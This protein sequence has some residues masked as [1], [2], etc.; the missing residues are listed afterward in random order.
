MTDVTPVVLLKTHSPKTR[1][2]RTIPITDE[3]ENE[4]V[5]IP[6]LVG[7]DNDLAEM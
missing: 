7:N 1:L 2:D 3:F 6:K 4:V 5:I